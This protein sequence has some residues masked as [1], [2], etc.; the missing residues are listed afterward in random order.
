MPWLNDY[1][2]IVSESGTG[3]HRS[4]ILP[5]NF[6]IVLTFILGQK[7]CNFKKFLINKSSPKKN[8]IPPS[9]P[10]AKRRKTNWLTKLPNIEL[11]PDKVSV[12]LSNFD[13]LLLGSINRTLRRSI[14]YRN[15]GSFGRANL[16]KLI[17]DCHWPYQQFG[18]SFGGDPI[19]GYIWGKLIYSG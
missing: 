15:R 10:I 12:I 13:A 16:D 14:S 17:I 18:S 7:I 11:N 19:S 2:Q 5:L 6:T 1:I 4:H 3:E 9:L 8:F